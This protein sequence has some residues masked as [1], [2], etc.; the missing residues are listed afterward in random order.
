MDV[1]LDP[2][3]CAEL[4]DICTDVAIEFS[5]AQIDS[6]A[7]V[8]GV[9]DS[10]CS[11]LPPDVYSELVAPRQHRLFDE[12]KAAGANVRLHVCGDMTHLLPLI[13]DLHVDILDVDHLVDI[14]TAREIMDNAIVLAGNLD[15][16]A[17]L[18]QGTPEA[19]RE[20]VN[21]V[22]DRTGNP[23][24]ATAGCEIPRDTPLENLLA[25]CEPVAYRP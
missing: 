9:G 20:Q 1:L 15:P 12:I 14:A 18:L 16:V 24:I 25:L 4:M 22:Y 2:E 17:D 19:I 13:K 5:R 7:D 6:G 10:I 8:I 3:W 11:Q 21:E 23:M